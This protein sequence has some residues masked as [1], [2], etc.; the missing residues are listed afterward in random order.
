MLIN[1]CYFVMEGLLLSTEK[2]DHRL[3]TFL[4][5]RTMPQLFERFVLE[6]Y[7]YH[8][9]SLN[10]RASQ[11]DWN[12]DEGAMDF[13]PVMQTDITLSHKGRILIIDTK[14]YSKTMQSRKDYNTQS[15]H[16]G[17]LYQIFTYVK[18]K[19]NDNTGNVSGLLLYAKTDEL[20][21]PDASFVM[22]GNPIKVK[23][24]DL[25]VAFKDIAEQ[26]DTIVTPLYQ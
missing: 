25:N 17:N 10:A 26:L 24:L 11:V 5:D 6:Y 1:I 2:G 8:H 19:D 22:A 21:T 12:I 7:R 18:N 13:L 16:S 3:A 9:P 4:D 23:T 15:L 20:I 14:F